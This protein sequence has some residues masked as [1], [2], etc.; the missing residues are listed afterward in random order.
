M[1]KLNSTLA[2]LCAAAVATA[3]VAFAIDSFRTQRSGIANAKNAGTV[4]ALRLPKPFWAASAPGRVEP[5]R[6]EIRI[7]SQLPGKVA[8]VLVRLNDTVKAGDLLVRLVDDEPMAKLGAVTTEVSVRRRERDA[9]TATKL[10]TDRRVAEDALSIAERAQFRLRME[11]DQA[12]QSLRAGKSTAEAVEAA[13]T[14]LSEAGDRIEQERANLRRI[15]SLPGMPLP[16]RLDSSLVT[17]RAELAVIEATIEHT[18]IRAPSDGTVLQVNTHA[19]EIVTPSPEDILLTFGDLSVLRVRAEI[20]ER[21]IPKVRVGQAVVVRSDTFPG[22]EFAGRVDR[23]AKALGTQR[24]SAR[25]PRKPTD[26]DVLMLVI[27]L[28][29]NTTLLPGMRVDVFFKPDNTKPENAA[30]KPAEAEIKSN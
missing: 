15:Q 1:L 6:G 24:L 21:D 16:T 28:D 22:M 3:G 11:L 9:E 23:M 20:E 7:G 13:R 10:A 19:G 30:A 8:Q 12:L 2:S 4:N 26:I 14:A 18:R 25:G 5:R 27:A 17:S 29:G